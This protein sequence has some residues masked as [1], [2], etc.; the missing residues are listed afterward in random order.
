MT[1]TD[2]KDFNFIWK[3]FVIPAIQGIFEQ[4]DPMFREKCK[5]SIRDLDKLEHDVCKCFFDRRENL[6][7]YYYG[8]N[9]SK[10]NDR[11][12]ISSKQK[13]GNDKKAD[14]QHLLDFHKLSSILCRSL[15]EHKVY[16][17]DLKSCINLAKEKK[18]DETDWLIKNVLINYRLA[19][20][21]SVVFL[22]QSMLFRYSEQ[23]SAFADKIVHSYL[24]E[25]KR[26]NLYF[27]DYTNENSVHESFENCL[28][29][30]LA[31]RDI[32]NRSFD[33]F[34][35]STIMYQLEEYNKL[36]AYQKNDSKH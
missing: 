21:A 8:K 15:I 14:E 4:S 5:L 17:L 36:L 9:Y 6:K 18:S 11:I 28:V 22:Y 3:T 19:F 32:D 31:K 12:I 26:L 27:S 30:D 25:Q 34:M 13:N 23:E 2:K 33:F 20:Y 29:L 16:S 7:K 35:Y 24:I 10:A 1:D